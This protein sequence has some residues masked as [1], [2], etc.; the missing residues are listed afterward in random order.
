MSDKR[1]TKSFL[2]SL[3]TL[4]EFVLFLVIIEI[5]LFDDVQFDGVESDDLQIGSALFARD[6][7]ALIRVRVNVD[8]CIAFGTCSGRHYFS[9]Q[10]SDEC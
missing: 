1:K 6:H 9:L 8:I 7:I 2:L 3:I 10:S 5:V 4:L